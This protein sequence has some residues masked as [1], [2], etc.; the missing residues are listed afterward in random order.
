MIVFINDITN[1]NPKC[2]VKGYESNYAKGKVT[3][4]T[5]YFP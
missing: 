2:N 3:C 5:S 1:T 4:S